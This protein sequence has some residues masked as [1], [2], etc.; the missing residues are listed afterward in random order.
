MGRK[1]IMLIKLSSILISSSEKITCAYKCKDSEHR[2][3]KI[4]TTSLDMML[5]GSFR[6][7]SAVFSGSLITFI[8]V[9]CH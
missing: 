7:S 9:W 4:N 6:V 2:K 3:T 1:M 5:P 8:S